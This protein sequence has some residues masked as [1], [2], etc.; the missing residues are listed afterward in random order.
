[1]FVS[2]DM[3]VTWLLPTCIKRKRETPA[4]TGI[5]DNA[6]GHSRR[7]TYEI[8]QVVQFLAQLDSSSGC[9]SRLANE[10]IGQVELIK[11]TWLIN[12]LA[13]HRYIYNTFW[14]LNDMFII[15]WKRT[16]G[17]VGLNP[18]WTITLF[19]VCFFFLLLFFVVVFFI[20]A[21]SVYFNHSIRMVAY[22]C[23]EVAR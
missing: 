17:F 1:M 22:F 16:P 21:V 19:F 18:L 7:F 10:T 15:D 2:H 13:L 14:F 20:V 9:C 12:G 4:D 3:K 8:D 6:L 23:H 11:L 5:M